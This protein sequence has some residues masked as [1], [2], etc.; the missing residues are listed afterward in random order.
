M[1]QLFLLLVLSSITPAHINNKDLCSDSIVN[2]SK[3]C[4][5]EYYLCHNGLQSGMTLLLS[6]SLNHTVSNSK[7]C[8]SENLS[9]VT[10]KS[11]SNINPAFIMCNKTWTGFGFYNTSN[12]TFN[13]LVFHQCG[14]EIQLSDALTNE[15]NFYFGPYQKAV[16][17]F[18]HCTN[19][20]LE[21]VNIVGPYSGFGIVAV[22]ALGNNILA[23]INV[24][25]NDPCTYTDGINGWFNFSCSGSGIVFLY[26]ETQFST[27]CEMPLIIASH[28]IL[29]RNCNSYNFEENLVN[30]IGP[31]YSQRPLISATGLTIIL[32]SNQHQVVGVFNNTEISYTFGTHAGGIVIIYHNTSLH[33]S[34]VMSSLLITHNYNYFAK[35]FSPG[36]SILIFIDHQELTDYQDV[37]ITNSVCKHNRGVI[38]VCIY[39]VTRSLS[40]YSM[41]LQ[42]GNTRFIGNIATV[43]GSCMYV[44]P[45][46]ANKDHFCS[47]F[48]NIHLTEV[49]ASRNGFYNDNPTYE[50]MKFDVSLFSFVNVRNVIVQGGSFSN[51]FGP[52]LQL[53]ESVLQ[54]NG[55]FYCE[56]NIATMG[57]CIFL[58]GFSRFVLRKVFIGRFINNKALT[59]GGAIYADNND[60]SSQLCTI[61]LH[62]AYNS[63]IYQM[64]FI[65]NTAYLDGDAIKID[66]LYNCFSYSRKDNI[67]PPSQLPEIYNTI[68]NVTPKRK[69]SISSVATRFCC[70]NDSLHTYNCK[71]LKFFSGQRISIPIIAVDAVNSPVYTNVLAIAYASVDHNKTQ[72]WTIDGDTINRLYPNKCNKLHFTILTTVGSKPLPGNI[73]IYT[74][75]TNPVIDYHL[76]AMPCP[77]GFIIANSKCDCSSFLYSLNK[78]IS[79]DIQTVTISLPYSSWFGNIS[80][81]LSNNT[82]SVEG[83]SSVCPPEYCYPSLT[84]YN[85]TMLNPLCQ[86]GR[87]GI[88]CGQCNDNLSLV[89]G[90]DEC[91]ECSNLWLLS[92]LG[93]ALIGL[94]LVLLLFILNLTVSNGTLGGLVFFANMSVVSLHTNL[95]VDK[96]YTLPVK[97]SLSFLN[98]NLG[99]PMCFYHGMDIT[100]KTGL[101]F[102]FPVYLW[103]LVLGLVIISRYSTRISNLIVGSSVQVLATLIQ[104]SFAKLLLTVSDIFTSAEVHTTHH[105]PL[106]VWY[107]GGNITYLSGGHLVLFLLSLLTSLLF[108]L[109][110][111]VITTIASHLR[112]YRLSKHIR[113][114]IDAYH[115]PYKDRLGYWFGVRQWLVVFLYIV[116]ANLRGVHPLIML[117]IHIVIVALFMIVQNHVK[118]FKNTLV[119]LLDTW[120]TFLL[121]VMDLLT[122]FFVSQD[123]SPQSGSIPAS[124]ILSLYLIS[125]IGVAIYHSI[126]AIRCLRQKAKYLYHQVTHL[127]KLYPK[128]SKLYVNDNEDACLREPLLENVPIHI[129][130]IDHDN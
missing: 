91:Q 113:P 41:F 127:F 118:P 119:N 116:Y 6:S 29:S 84:T 104:L 16:L 53:F 21:S 25:D 90:S 19:T 64:N 62:Y 7:F 57:A 112:K 79:C 125:V 71:L 3:V 20:H 66:N 124:I 12:L 46:T 15:S 48:H 54:L 8:L 74:V 44:E 45:M 47:G 82:Q 130:D 89:F 68:F 50:Y 24:T 59:S 30:L 10:I 129:V 99:Y 94:L 121:F 14:G 39:I 108:L 72:T 38:G 43:Q 58:K 60:I 102:V 31:T 86:Y 17:L 56:N 123:G 49:F 126:V 18:S 32:A 5:L 110:Y 61:Q 33:H 67:I 22:N 103:S 120:F 35:H 97:L 98:L 105:H 100:G 9:N 115:G 37:L 2:V 13:D 101:Q 83:F 87:T 93:Y 88:I 117:I 107:F 23:H 52:V 1:K 55:L 75:K 34:L 63:T 122:F 70:C 11:D 69:S 114:L 96:L 128:S 92:I 73:K 40:M 27:D 4:P 26:I 78:N 65:N 111:L 28:L 109:P 85:A 106:I 36:I 76:L 77:F 42:I 95:L 81:L 80:S 51:N